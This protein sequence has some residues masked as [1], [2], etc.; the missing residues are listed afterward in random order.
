MN[1]IL[2]MKKSYKMRNTLS[3]ILNEMHTILVNSAVDDI[4]FLLALMFAFELIFEEDVKSVLELVF[5]LE[6]I[7]EEDVKSV[8]ELNLHYLEI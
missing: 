2:Q 7:F 4:F 6:L 5:V 8:L 3:E 1:V